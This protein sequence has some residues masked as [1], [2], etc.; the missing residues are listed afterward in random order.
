MGICKRIEISKYKTIVITFIRDY[1]SNV[2]RIA[3]ALDKMF[4]K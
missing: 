2:L 4:N 3:N 1:A